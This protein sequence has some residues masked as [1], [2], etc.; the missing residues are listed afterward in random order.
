MPE[1][2]ASKV[3]FNAGMRGFRKIHGGKSGQHKRHRITLKRRRE[4]PW[5]LGIRH[6]TGE[7]RRNRKPRTRLVAIPRRAIDPGFPSDNGPNEQQ[8]ALCVQP[9]THAPRDNGLLHVLD[10]FRHLLGRTKVRLLQHEDDL[11]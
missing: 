9:R 3:R 7:T 8:C 11:F 5:T 1:R 10:D 4:A 2:V 6:V